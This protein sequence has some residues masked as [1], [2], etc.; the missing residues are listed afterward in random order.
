M[1]WKVRDTDNTAHARINSG[2]WGVAVTG[3]Q[4]GSN[5][6]QGRYTTVDGNIRIV[7]T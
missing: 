5:P 1:E 3:S 4:N 7:W 6:Y 2:F